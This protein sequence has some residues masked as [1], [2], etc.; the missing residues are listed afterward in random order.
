MCVIRLNKINV[1]GPSVPLLV[2]KNFLSFYLRHLNT[3]GPL[4]CIHIH[5]NSPPNFAIAHTY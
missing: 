3:S 5:V 1:N 2:F 4:S